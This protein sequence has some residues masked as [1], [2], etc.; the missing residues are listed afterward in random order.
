M[1][2]EVVS[3]RDNMKSVTCRLEVTR[4]AEDRKER[5]VDVVIKERPVTIFLND[6]E[7]ATLMCTPRSLEYLA[8]GFLFAEGLVRGKKD[9]K[10]VFAEEE[11][12]VV[13]VETRNSVRLPE[14]L[15]ARRY[16]TTGCG[17]SLTFVDASKAKTDLRIHSEFKLPIGSVR[18]LMKEFFQKSRLFKLTGGVHSAAICSPVGILVYNEDIGRHSAIDKAVGECVLK[19]IRTKDRILLTSGR[20]SSDILVKTARSGAAILVS[21][22]APTDLAVKLAT[23]FGITLIGFARGTRMNVYSNAWRIVTKDDVKERTR[24]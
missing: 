24:K 23:D 10:R 16:V 1:S 7:V 14:N 3:G 19:G 18:K 9:I 15:V 2:P 20:I 17:K 4:L 8:I 11:D 13:W 5:L 22:S 6:V 21:K 12:G